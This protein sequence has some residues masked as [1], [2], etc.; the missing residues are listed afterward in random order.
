[1]EILE[2]VAVRVIVIYNFLQ[3]YKNE[4]VLRKTSVLK[5]LVLLLTTEREI[6]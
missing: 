1:M 5:Y 6:E 3:T 2:F 4:Y